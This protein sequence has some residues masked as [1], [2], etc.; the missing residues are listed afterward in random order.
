MT[1]ATS[2]LI[3]GVMPREQS[4]GYIEEWSLVTVKARKRNNPPRRKG[5]TLPRTE[6]LAMDKTARFS[7]QVY[8]ET[9]RKSSSHWLPLSSKSGYQSSKC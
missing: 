5:K 1:E 9:S 6:M 8:L 2:G 7:Q 4:M 3:D